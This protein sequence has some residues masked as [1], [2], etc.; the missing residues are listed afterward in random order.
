MILTLCR[1]YVKGVSQG[2]SS[3]GVSVLSATRRAFRYISLSALNH[4]SKSC[5]IFRE[6]NFSSLH[7]NRYCKI[8][9]IFSF[10]IVIR[11]SLFRFVV[12]LVLVV[13]LNTCERSSILDSL[14]GLEW[15]PTGYRIHK[16]S[17]SILKT[18]V[19][20]RAMILRFM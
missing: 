14:I 11:F 20:T 8:P 6:A 16:I 3:N 13:Y 12:L 5:Y 10:K 15:I 4:K 19:S 2:R 1:E 7:I 17:I 18:Q 9:L